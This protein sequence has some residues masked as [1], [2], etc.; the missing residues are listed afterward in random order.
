M[1]GVHAAD[2][3]RSPEG[4]RSSDAA[5]RLSLVSGVAFAVPIGATAVAYVIGEANA[6]EDNWPAYALGFV[7]FAGFL[8]ALLGFVLGV[9][10]LLRGKAWKDLRLPLGLFPAIVTFLVIG[11]LFVWE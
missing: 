11:E 5:T 6:V 4:H 3:V 10:F 1:T 8:G 7:A 2:A 9:V